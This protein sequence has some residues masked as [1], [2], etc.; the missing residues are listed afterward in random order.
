MAS[1]KAA[2]APADSAHYAWN[3]ATAARSAELASLGAT[4]APTLVR[5]G[6]ASP[7]AGATS[8]SGGSAWNA[9]GTW[10]VRRAVAQRA[11]QRRRAF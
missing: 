3:A 11:L 9:A 5:A 8:P 7:A 4:T 2:A 1:E 10:C 6:D